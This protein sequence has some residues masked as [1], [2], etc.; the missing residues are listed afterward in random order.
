MGNVETQKYMTNNKNM[1]IKDL[2]NT[3]TQ[4]PK[5]YPLVTKK[6]TSYRLRKSSFLSKLEENI[7]PLSLEVINRS[8][9]DGVQNLNSWLSF[10]PYGS[11][12]K[13]P[14]F[15]DIFNISEEV[16]TGRRKSNKDYIPVYDDESEWDWESRLQ[17]IR[18]FEKGLDPKTLKSPGQNKDTAK[19]IKPLKPSLENSLIIPPKINNDKA[20]YEEDHNQITDLIIKDGNSDNQS[21]ASKSP[22]SSDDND[23][24]LIED[25][26][27]KNLNLSHYKAKPKVTK[28]WDNSMKTPKD[29]PENALL[30]KSTKIGRSINTISSITSSL[31]KSTPSSIKET[32]K[33]TNFERIQRLEALGSQLLKQKTITDAERL[34]QTLN[35]QFNAYNTLDSTHISTNQ[36]NSFRGERHKSPELNK[37]KQ[38][39]S[40][41]NSSI[42]STARLRDHRTNQDFE[43]NATGSK[44]KRNYKALQTSIM[45]KKSQNASVDE[46]QDGEIDLKNKIKSL[47]EELNKKKLVLVDKSSGGKRKGEKLKVDTKK[48]RSL[49]KTKPQRSPSAIKKQQDNAGIKHIPSKIVNKSTGLKKIG[50]NSDYS[51]ESGYELNQ[52]FQS[53]RPVSGKKK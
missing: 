16:H 9:S 52:S 5:S 26:V 53:G 31:K 35:S 12:I 10:I 51:F 15:S 17:K 7:I 43:K 38:D 34:K 50:Y 2:L 37:S 47:N 1:D 18:N 30:T 22:S 42:L 44:F 32:P 8:L 4:Y 23:K 46:S 3:K 19:Q 49:S 36:T 45:S 6:Q 14:D 40:I 39:Q 28:K 21:H 27:Y 41:N 20:S 48:S 24:S 13:P 29:I 33:L 11:E 25:I